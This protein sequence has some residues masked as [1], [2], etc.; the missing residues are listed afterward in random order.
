MAT[1][2][3]CVF[4]GARDGTHPAFR[5]SAE[6]LGRSL[7]RRGLELIYGGASVGTMGALADAAIAAGGR[8][9]GV[10]P[11]GLV[12]RELAHLSLTELCTVPTLA[13]RKELMI[14]LAD[15]FIALP[16]G[17]GTLDEIFEVLS[18]RTLD[19]HAKPCALLDVRGYYRPLL[20]AID[21]GVEEGFVSEDVRDAL[22]VSAD[23]DELLD[24]LLARIRPQGSGS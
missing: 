8:V 3:V 20:A 23:P 15:A 18:T 2:R 12:D 1:A 7:A 9:V 13:R 10:I 11:Q 19:L 6:S 22:I 4:C 24:E 21:R 14:D 5:A 16:G 17:L